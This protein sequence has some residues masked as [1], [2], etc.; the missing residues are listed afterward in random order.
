MIACGI[1]FFFLVEF[2]DG[3]ARNSYP[4]PGILRSRQ[5]IITMYVKNELWGLPGVL[6]PNFS[7][8]IHFG[9]FPHV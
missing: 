4:S 8:S 2:A 1:R 5:R 6:T 3:R 9:D 7:H